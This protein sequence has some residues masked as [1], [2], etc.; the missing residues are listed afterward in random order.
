[1]YTF[2]IEWDEDKDLDDD[3]YIDY[4]HY[5]LEGPSA[6]LPLHVDE[7]DS[8]EMTFAT[9]VRFD[10]DPINKLEGKC[11]DS[12]ASQW[13]VRLIPLNVRAADTPPLISTFANAE[14][15]PP[16]ESVSITSQGDLWRHDHVIAL[17]N[18]GDWISATCTN[19]DI[20]TVGLHLLGD[21]NDG[22]GRVLVDGQ[23]V[24]R[25]NVYGDPDSEKGTFSYYLEVSGLDPGVH[26]IQLEC[27]GIP[28]DGGGIHV[29]MYYFGFSTGPV[30]TP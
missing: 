12:A 17:M 15:A 4:Y 18:E 2:C 24:W 6:D 23:E 14:Y 9:E 8:I 22:W 13:Q 16:P 11:A 10:T 29:A 5:I 3:G 20:T 26:T 25:G 27:L 7:N 21:T 1:V 30:Y 19:P 28:G